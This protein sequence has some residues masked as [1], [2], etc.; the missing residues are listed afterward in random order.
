MVFIASLTSQASGQDLVQVSGILANSVTNL[1]A[2]GQTIWV[3]PHLNV[4]HD[5]GQTWN[6]VNTDSLSGLKNTVY[7]IDIERNV[8]WVGLGDSYIQTNSGGQ[9]Q[10][11]HIITGLL[12]SND[13]GH[14]WRYISHFP[15]SGNDP[16]TTGLLDFPDDTLITYGRNQLRT[17]AVTV[18][19]LSPP[20]DIDYGP[21]TGDL[22]VASAVAGLRKSTDNGNSWQ[23][24]ILPPDTSRYISPDLDYVFPFFS[25]PGPAGI[26]ISRF[27]G[28]NFGAYSVLVDETGTVWA[29][30]R[31]G[32]NK[33]E[34]S[35]I[36]WRHITTKDGLLGNIVYSIEEQVRPGLSPAIWMTNRAGS[37]YP[38]EVE[39]SG[40]SVTY[41]HGVTFRN[42]LHGQKCFDF[43]FDGR[44]IYVACDEG[45]FISRD[46]GVTFLSNRIFFTDELKSSS[47]QSL[48][49]HS[50]ALTNGFIWVGTHDG[51][52]QSSDGGNSWR[53]FRAK[54]PLKPEELPPM[55]PAEQVP[56]VRT[57]AYP[58][59]FSPRTDQLVWLRYDLKKVQL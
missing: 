31:G 26:P 8:I 2:E 46:N 53:L 33:S 40:V 10:D 48:R 56:E 20:W 30:T 57:F 47:R 16:N 5:N 9:T 51:L 3:G 36:S 11:I 59:P 4:S 41:D 21:N 45:L 27:H 35:G 28:Y 58:N 54:V 55:I 29:G 50:V 6:A 23:R 24:I 12:N 18:P 1:H 37:L 44:T 15:R 43:A 49:V 19:D 7:S 32:L 17:L 13:H 52:F 14:T 25:L 39:V 38:D 34:D 22:W 42:V